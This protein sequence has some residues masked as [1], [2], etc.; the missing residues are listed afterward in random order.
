MLCVIN[1]QEFACAREIYGPQVSPFIVR[2]RTQRKPRRGENEVHGMPVE[3]RVLILAVPR[4]G[5]MSIK[6]LNSLVNGQRVRFST[7]FCSIVVLE[8]IN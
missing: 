6:S 8:P 7:S 1:R 2:V 5:G 3:W 4:L